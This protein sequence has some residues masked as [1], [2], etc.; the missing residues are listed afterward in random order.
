MRVKCPAQHTA[1]CP[2]PGLK[3][4]SLNLGMSSL[5][6]RPPHLPPTKYTTDFIM[7]KNITSERCT[8]I[9]GYYKAL[10][11]LYKIIF[12]HQAEVLDVQVVGTTEDKVNLRQVKM[13]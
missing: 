12:A 10:L 5:T 9:W 7:Q 8:C 11:A 4:G 2:R 3:A 13:L 1:P 6:M